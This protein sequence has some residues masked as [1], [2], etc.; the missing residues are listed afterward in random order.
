MPIVETARA[1]T[2]RLMK[3]N[4]WIYLLM[5]PSIALTFVFAY[6]PMPGILTSFQDYNM[7]KGMMKSPW[8]GLKHIRAIFELPLMWGS[9][10]NTLKLSLLTILV[11]F[12]APIILA[13]LINELKNGIFKRTIQTLSYLPYFLSWIAVVGITYS[14]FDVYG[15][16]NDL[17]VAI[18]GQDAQRLMFLSEQKLFI[19]FLLILTVWKEVGFG[20]IVYLAAITSIDPSLY[21]A[22]YIDGANRLK[23]HFY[24]TLPGIK[25]TAIILLIF[26]MGNLFGSNFELVYGMQNAF[27]NFDV[28]ST[29]VF[30]SGVQQGNYSAAA[31]IGFTQGLVAFI[32]TFTVNQISKKV[33][34]ISIW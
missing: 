14:F 12:P 13:M 28:I 26:T 6:L 19:P 22:A 5:L 7:F 32:L 11:S 33:S 18:L 15:P 2:W 3:K 17:R 8:V 16:I 1:K 10:L 34:Q 21:E 30:S 25:S 27:I 4:K 24:I 31:A 23:M 20:T 9:I 29:V